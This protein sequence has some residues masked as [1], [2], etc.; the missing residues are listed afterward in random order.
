MVSNAVQ[1]VLAL[2]FQRFFL[3]DVRRIH[4]AV[5]IG[6]LKFSERVVVGWCLDARVKNPNLL[7]WRDIVINDH[8]LAADNGHL[9]DFSGVEPTAVNDGGAILREGERHGGYILHARGN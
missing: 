7:E 9:P 5:M 8:A 6:V 3:F 1:E 4:V 2:R